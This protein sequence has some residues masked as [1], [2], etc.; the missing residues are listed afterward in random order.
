MLS[1]HFLRGVAL[2]L[3]STT[4]LCSAVYAQDGSNTQEGSG[5]TNFGSVDHQ[6]NVSVSETS[7]TGED[8][9]V[10]NAHLERARA[11]LEPA[12]GATTYR[13]SRQNIEANPGGDNAPMTSLLVQAPGVALDSYGQ[14][15]IRGDHNEVQFRLDGVALPEGTSVFGQALMTRFAHDLSLTTGALPSEYGFLQAGVIDITTKNGFADAG[16]DVSL[17]GGAR[18]YFQPSVQYG[19]HK[20]KWDWFATADF[21]HNR[22]GIE[23]T[24]PNF[25][26]LHD[27]TNQYH[28]LGHA[29]YTVD[30]DTRLSLT[31]GVSNAEYQLPNN[32]GQQRQFADPSFLNSSLSQKVYGS[33]DS[34][35]LNEHQK[36]ITDF[37]ILSLQKELGHLSVQSSIVTR[38]SS[39]RYTP[40]PLGDLVYNGI[41]QNAARGVF[42]TGNQTD[43]TWRVSSAH[44]VRFGYQTYVERNISK[45][46]SS[47]YPQT[48][49]DDSGNPIYGNTP[50]GIH[51]GTG[52]TGW[53]YGLYAQDE[54]RPVHNLTVNYG[55]RFDGVD[56]YTHAKQ[57]SP[58]LNI[59]YQPWRGGVLHAG[60]SRYFTPPPFELV[61]GTSLLPFANTS[62]A[63][64]TFQND[65]PRAE[66]DHYFDAGI[67]QTILPGWH[68]SFD[69][70]VKLA[71]NMIDEGQFG[72]PVLL[73]VFNYR[74][75]QVHGYEFTTDYTHGPFSVYGNMSW[76]RAMGKDIVSAQWNFSPDD[77]SY[78][79]NRWIH[80]DHDQRWTASAGGSYTAFDRS[81]HPLRMSASMMYGSGLRADGVVPNGASVPQYAT[82]NLSF[83]QSFQNLFHSRFFKTTQLRLDV[84]NLFDRTYLLRDGSGIGVGAPQYGL[85]RTI[86]TGIEQRF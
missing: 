9:I 42:S 45:T 64:G 5:R 2:S 36:E 62:A 70:Y 79:Q 1:S 69:A 56:E 31:A 6:K 38:Y 17:Y 41:A 12:T 39:L 21:V 47:V 68:A 83:V 32:P 66:R 49:A 35:G 30:A 59:V 29:R 34:A 54:W 61:G 52:R 76:S 20:G 55:L 46:D 78:I 58:R 15:H 28:F 73:S 48:G 44:T 74:R 23:N 63:P 57:V 72:S 10:V 86:L 67:A 51:S 7:R 84:T 16:G 3:L 65:T 80:L 77:L 4:A 82:F 8:N 18:D 22:V 60:Y 75:G 50:I 27:L 13:F 53:M 71:K 24:E 81:S 43:A 11:A 26:A 33:V 19:G 14:I 25:N 85:R 40:D 37:G